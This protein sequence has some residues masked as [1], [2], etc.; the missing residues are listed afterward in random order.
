MFSVK[1][2]F[3]THEDFRTARYPGRT[4]GALADRLQRGELGF[5][6]STLGCFKCW[7]EEVYNL[8]KERFNSTIEMDGPQWESVLNPNQQQQQ[9][10][11]LSILQGVLYEFEKNLVEYPRESRNQKGQMHNV[12][13][14]LDSAIVKRLYQAKRSVIDRKTAPVSDWLTRVYNFETLMEDPE[15]AN[16]LQDV[17]KEAFEGCFVAVCREHNAS[18]LASELSRDMEEEEIDRRLDAYYAGYDSNLDE[19]Q[20]DEFAMEVNKKMSR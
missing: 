15:V 17:V 4:I 3:R 2:I 5:Y 18:L 12:Y 8:L 6:S 14:Q 7:K 20:Q 9:K 1:K 19:E 13:D 11:I 10:A 16:D